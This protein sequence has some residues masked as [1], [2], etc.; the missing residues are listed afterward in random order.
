[1]L[2]AVRGAENIAVSATEIH[3]LQ[4]LWCTWEDRKEAIISNR[5]KEKQVTIQADS[6]QKS[7]IKGLSMGTSLMC[8]WKKGGYSIMCSYKKESGERRDQGA[9]DTEPIGN[10]KE[11]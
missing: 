7:K 11:C 5:S 1:M 6:Q 3:E 4:G 10:N 9:D 2:G 8:L